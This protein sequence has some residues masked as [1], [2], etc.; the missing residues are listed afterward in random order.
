MDRNM[1]PKS[2]RVPRIP[3]KFNSYECKKLSG[4][5][6]GCRKVVKDGDKGVV[7][8]PCIAYWHY[9]CANVTQEQIETVWKEKFVCEAHRL[10]LECAGSANERTEISS[11]TTNN[12]EDV[13]LTNI[14]INSYSIDKL[15]KIKFKIN[16]M[17]N[18]PFLEEKACNRQHTITLNSV[19]YQI[20]V[21]NFI[22]F[23]ERLGVNPKRIDKTGENVQ[24]QY[25]MNI[26]NNIP[27][28]V[29]YFHTTNNILVQLK[30][31][32]G[33]RGAKK[34]SKTNE[35][36]VHLRSFVNNN[37]A[38]LVKSI[39][40]D[41]HYPAMKDDMKAMLEELLEATQQEQQGNGHL[42]LMM[43]T[44]NQ[45]MTPYKQL[46]QTP[47]S[48]KTPTPIQ[49]LTPMKTPTSMNALENVSEGACGGRISS[50]S[51]LSPTKSPGRKKGKKCND[52]CESTRCR[53]NERISALERERTALKN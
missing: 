13:V 27:V 26:N 43:S 35:R 46:P 49:T 10:T 31:E 9:K 15:S 39:E 25:E 48:M 47:T 1:S 20:L 2:V 6:P 30:S 5:C 12:E 3:I 42:K 8:E 29:T 17:E 24:D 36:I 37:L 32:K 51:K 18:K 28:S 16:N 41:S 40:K 7:C 33:L 38:N 22:G 14:K 11:S 50:P 45:N 21:G 44:E 23:G 4:F 34:I 52:D 53:L 19:T